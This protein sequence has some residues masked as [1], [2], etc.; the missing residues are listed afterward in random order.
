M[1]VYPAIR[2]SKANVIADLKSG[3]AV[4]F[5]RRAR[6][7]A[8]LLPLQVA[9]S[10][11]VVIAA[12]LLSASLIRSLNQDNGFRLSGTVFA[13]TSIQAVLTDDADKKE[14]GRPQEEKLKAKL[15]LYRS[16]LDRLDR[17]PGIVSASLSRMHPL[18][19]IGYYSAIQT[20]GEKTSR[21]DHEAA[22]NW[23]APRY[24]ET[25]GTHLLRG[26]EFS[27]AD[28]F[29][30]RKV[31]ILSASAARRLFPDED[32]I[33]RTLVS[34]SNWGDKSGK[35]LITVVGVVEDTRWNGMQAAMPRMYYFPVDQQTDFVPSLQIVLRTDD[36]ATALASVRRILRE[37]AGAQITDVVSIRDEVNRSLGQPRLLAT[38]S[39]ALAGLALLLSAVAIYGLLSYS[40]KQRT[41]EIA[42]RMAVGASRMDVIRMIARQAAWLILPGLAAGTLG[43]VGLSRV[44]KSLLYQTS[45]IDPAAF[46]LS[47]AALFVVAV[48]A[49]LMPA[50]RAASVEPMEALRSE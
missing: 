9:F 17:A 22:M 39:N 15:A 37:E 6:L 2:G 21:S 49:T 50:R 24:F 30:G 27:V 32:A 38:L 8:F 43:A 47:L 7:G 20:A 46:S 34:L 14:K 41:A 12:G 3:G 16:I 25:L 4:S 28:R 40:V 44:F 11:V 36:T 42:V 33:G 19:L 13:H 48:A 18:G 10:V 23:V 29:D 26:R 45:P 35:G 31:C 5:G 1:G